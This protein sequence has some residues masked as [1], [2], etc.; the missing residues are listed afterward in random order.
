MIEGSIETPENSMG[1]A[2]MFV[3]GGRQLDQFP[4]D[5]LALAGLI[6]KLF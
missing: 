3:V 1:N 2:V 5:K 4:S 6:G